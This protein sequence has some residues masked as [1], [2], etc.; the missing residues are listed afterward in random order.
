MPIVDRFFAFCIRCMFWI[1]VL[2]QVEEDIRNI[3]VQ[4]FSNKN[5]RL[6]IEGEKIM[7]DKK[8]MKVIKFE[9]IRKYVIKGEPVYMVMMD[10]RLAEISS[11][12]RIEDILFH[13]ITGGVF[14][15]YK[16][17]IGAGSFTKSI[18]LGNWTL[19]VGH[20]PKAGDDECV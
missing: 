6:F 3:M 8:I 9:T 11:E 7:F 1:S 19:S 4:V 16:R 5:N 20:T 15:V 13:N 14:A 17:P 2:F 12:T 10:G 18:K